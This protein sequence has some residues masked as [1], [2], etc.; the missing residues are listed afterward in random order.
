MGLSEPLERPGITSLN[1]F[2]QKTLTVRSKVCVRQSSE[3]G[4]KPANL[5]LSALHCRQENKQQC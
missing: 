2:A 4:Q 3:T 5:K 1:R